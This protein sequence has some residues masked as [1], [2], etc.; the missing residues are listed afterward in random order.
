MGLASIRFPITLFV[1]RMDARPIPTEG[2][3]PQLTSSPC[4]EGQGIP[5]LTSGVYCFVGTCAVRVSPCRV[6]P[7]LHSRYAARP[8]VGSQSVVHRPRG[9]CDRQK[10]ERVHWVTT[11]VFLRKETLYLATWKHDSVLHVLY[12]QSSRKERRD[13]IM[14]LLGHSSPIASP[15]GTPLSSPGLCGRGVFSGG[16]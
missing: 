9:F 8:A 10:K 2:V 4:L 16:Y 12:R 11:L 13:K 7:S 1:G 5:T 14:G 6:F 15:K 3:Q